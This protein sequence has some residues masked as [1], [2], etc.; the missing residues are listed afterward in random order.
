MFIF[1]DTEKYNKKLLGIIPGQG[2][3]ILILVESAF[4]FIT[5]SYFG[6]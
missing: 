5:S 6:S 4:Y 2:M 3:C 1:L